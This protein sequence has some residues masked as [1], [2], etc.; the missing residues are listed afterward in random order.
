MTLD[1]ENKQDSIESAYEAEEGGRGLSAGSDDSSVDWNGDFALFND[2]DVWHAVACQSGRFGEILA[3]RPNRDSAYR[4]GIALAGD[5]IESFLGE[6]EYLNV[7]YEDR[8]IVKHL[9]A[10]F[11]GDAK[12]W[13]IPDS[14]SAP[15]KFDAFRFSG[16]KVLDRLYPVAVRRNA[17]AART[18][19]DMLFL[20][21]PYQEKEIAKS[22]GAVWSP[23]DKAWFVSRKGPFRM[24]P[25]RWL[26]EGF[27]PASDLIM[28]PPDPDKP[29]RLLKVPRDERSLAAQSGAVYLES[30]KAWY[31][32]GALYNSHLH[33][34]WTKTN[35]L[36]GPRLAFAEMLWRTGFNPG[37]PGNLKPFRFD[38]E[39]HRY[40][41]LE[42]RDNSSA[43]YRGFITHE[44]KGMLTA[45]INNYS[46]SYYKTWSYP[47]AGLPWEEMLAIP[48]TQ[49]FM[50]ILHER[51]IAEI[52]QLQAKRREKRGFYR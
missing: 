43:R 1:E 12:A 31:V 16:W 19:N 2:G 4:A 32:Q 29:P 23:R 24:L 50:K 40:Y 11:D 6:R 21:V 14:C 9:G 51:M 8:T 15:S 13:F 30:K 17:L 26:P 38:G 45:Y 10:F 33:Y 20:K 7:R 5:E 52:E 34:R 27:R 46:A 22:A 49:Q 37:H 39:H 3:T 41:L 47:I 25:R 36:T 48:L 35:Q 28:L 18:A 44:G 42:D